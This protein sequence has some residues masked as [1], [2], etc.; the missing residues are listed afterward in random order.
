MRHCTFAAHQEQP[1]RSFTDHQP[2]A[3]ALDALFYTC[4]NVYGKFVDRQRMAG[5]EAVFLAVFSSFGAD[6][7]PRISS[8]RGAGC[9]REE[10]LHEAEQQRLHARPPGNDP[11]R[12]QIRLRAGAR[13]KHPHIHPSA[14]GGHLPMKLMSLNDIWFSGVHLSSLVSVAHTSV[15]SL[16]FPLSDICTTVFLQCGKDSR[17]DKHSRNEEESDTCNPH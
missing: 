12:R 5:C 11:G 14:A 9:R 17:A 16:L 4:P 3:S 1:S 10:A 6:N 15:R 13:R 2:K 7:I 8:A